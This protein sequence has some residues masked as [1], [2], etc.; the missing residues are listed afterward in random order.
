YIHGIVIDGARWDKHTASLGESEPKKLF[1][2]LP[3]IF[4]TA[5]NKADPKAV[6]QGFD[7]PLYRYP[8]RTD[9][10]LVCMIALPTKSKKP[11]HWI[12]RGVALLCNA[13]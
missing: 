2:P 13:A 1:S 3:V 7:A 8:I 12:L 5:V 6:R 4:V 9:K 10:H 11:Q